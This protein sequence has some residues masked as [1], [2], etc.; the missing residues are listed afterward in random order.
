MNVR[1]I[2][3][4]ALLTVFIAP[5]ARADAILVTSPTTA[6]WWRVPTYSSTNQFDYIDDQQTGHPEAD[7]VGSPANPAFY[8]AFNDPNHTPS[9][10]DGEIAYRVRV[11]GDR[12]PTIGGW[13]KV[14]VIGMDV[15][16]NGSLDVFMTA[17]RNS[18]ANAIWDAGPGANISPSTTTIANTPYQ[19]FAWTSN[20]FYYTNVSTAIDPPVTDTDLDD[21]GY[22]DWFV[23][24]SLPFT[25]LVLSVRALTGVDINEQSRVAYVVAT[26]T[27]DNAFNQDLNGIPKTYNANATWQSL[28]ALSDPI[29]I[30]EPGCVML[31]GVG[32]VCLLLR[33][34][35]ASAARRGH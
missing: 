15:D 14:L 33:R 9:L 28:G 4:M 8:T 3:V 29:V 19:T 5:T 7:I 27:Q 32:L 10:L 16:L 17:S 24:F 22:T 20:N 26:S 21:D 1:T 11:G 2:V 23:T 34:N 30:P 25:N 18:Q 6:G 12:T 13:D 35:T 31:L